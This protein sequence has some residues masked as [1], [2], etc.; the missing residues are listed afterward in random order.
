MDEQ[1]RLVG[2]NEVVFRWWTLSAPML[3]KYAGRRLRLPSTL[4]AGLLGC[5]RGMHGST[6]DAAALSEGEERWCMG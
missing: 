4:A 1:E 2:V 5:R 3:L 6:A